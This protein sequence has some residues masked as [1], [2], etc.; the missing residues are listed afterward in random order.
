[1]DNVEFEKLLVAIAHKEVTTLPDG[2][3]DEQERIA[4]RTLERA[5]RPTV[6][7]EIGAQDEAPTEEAAP[8]EEAIAKVEAPKKA[9]RNPLRRKR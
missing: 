5:A 3:G 7:V 9:S 8:V 2:L 6:H 4:L 1:M